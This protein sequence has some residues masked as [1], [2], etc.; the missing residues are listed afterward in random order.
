MSAYI[1]RHFTLMEVFVPLWCIIRR[2]WKRWGLHAGR[3]VTGAA[4]VVSRLRLEVRG[5]WA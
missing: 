3:L 5:T 2:T 1:N 4:L